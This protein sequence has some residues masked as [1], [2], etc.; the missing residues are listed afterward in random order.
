M[1]INLTEISQK[2][3]DTVSNA[4]N[5]F[6]KMYDLHYNPT[7]LDVQMEYIDENGVKR[8]TQVPN[9]SKMLG[10]FE[11]WKDGVE[12]HMPLMPNLLRNTKNFQW[13]NHNKA[14]FYDNEL[15]DGWSWGNVTDNNGVAGDLQFRA[16]V[17]DASDIATLDSLNIPH[18]FDQIPLCDEYGSDVS[19]LYLEL[20]KTKGRVVILAQ[21]SHTYT[22]WNIGNFTTGIKAYFC[23]VEATGDIKL[24][25]GG[26]RF[27]PV[28]ADISD[29][30]R[31]WLH[32]TNHKNGFG[33]FIQGAVEG[34]GTMKVAIALPYAY[35]GFLPD[36]IHAW[37][38]YVGTSASAYTHNDVIVGG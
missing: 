24:R 21:D 13:T 19:I 32:K 28:F 2:V 25:L 35:A 20:Q 10:E 33:G 9:R 31:G 23:V 34:N 36:H 38:G 27:A 7:P 37:A 6:R 12:G 5:V 30:N 22:A 17:I 15:P 11:E 16:M 26:N 8:T 4:S 3:L 14:T 18:P 29:K 1:G